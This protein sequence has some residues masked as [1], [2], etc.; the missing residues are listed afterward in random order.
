MVIRSSTR[1]ARR[2]RAR[3]ESNAE[4]LHSDPGDPP[5]CGDG[6]GLD[7]ASTTYCS[8]GDVSR[9]FVF[10]LP[11]PDSVGRG[12]HKKRAC[13]NR[14]SFFIFDLLHRDPALADHSRAEGLAAVG[15]A[16]LDSIPTPAR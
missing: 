6:F 7:M 12:A 2:S 4:E 15:L 8:S 3:S 11:F 14:F 1:L 9:I 13:I 10:G 16:Y 5:F